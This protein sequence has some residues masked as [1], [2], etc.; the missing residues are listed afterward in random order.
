MVR[1]YFLIGLF[2]ISLQI[3]AQQ[4]T[5]EVGN[6]V[7]N[8]VKLVDV[9]NAGSW[10]EISL[11]L[12]PTS[13]VNGTLHA[14]TGKSPFI[15][16]DQ[17]GN[18]YALK[19]QMGWEGPDTGGYGTIQLPANQKKY[20]KL[21][22][23]K[24]DNL[25]EIYSLTELNCKGDGCWNFY[26]IKLKDKVVEKEK[27]VVQA[28][29]IKTWVDFH[30]KNDAGELGMN[31]HAK[32]TIHNLKD[33]ECFL[34]VRFM[35]DKD[36]FLKTEKL[37]YANKSGQISLYRKLTPIYNQATFNDAKVFIPYSEF[38]LKGEHNLKYD[39]DIIYEN[40]ELI[41]HLHIQKFKYS[42]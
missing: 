29:Y 33:G 42:R 40:G 18:R 30:V 35:N 14:P 31:I 4:K 26:D 34:L 17:R 1:K 2:L 41:K 20:V 22:F 11:E 3:V 39:L 23:N 10:T 7:S 6:A 5:V 36:E 38:N 28:T 19:T 24:L 12:L 37:K 13:T 15:L 8:Y 25:D 16:S 32:F 9:Q 27:P 21:F